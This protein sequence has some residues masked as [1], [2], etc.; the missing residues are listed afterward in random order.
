MG[1]RLVEFAFR[2][3]CPLLYSDIK[4][5]GKG[6]RGKWRCKVSSRI[7]SM[8]LCAEN[9]MGLSSDVLYTLPSPALL[10]T[11]S[12]YWRSCPPPSFYFWEATVW[13]YLIL[14]NP[15]SALYTCKAVQ[16]PQ[17]F[18]PYLKGGPRRVKSSEPSQRH[19][20]C[21]Q[22]YL[23][24][25]RVKGTLSVASQHRQ[26]NHESIL[27]HIENREPLAPNQCPWLT[28]LFVQVNPRTAVTA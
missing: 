13:F 3:R 23:N 1:L 26:D 6:S 17:M 12:F 7:F 21:A 28:L 4:H 9:T 24:W 19:F 16:T 20:S 22:L 11:W 18:L 15:F 27:R 10:C 8:C 25:Q 2:L 14:P 5:K